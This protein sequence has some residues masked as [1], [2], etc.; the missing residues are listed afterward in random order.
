MIK[1]ISTSHLLSFFTLLFPLFFLATSVSAKDNHTI[2][3][4]FKGNPATIEEHTNKG[5]WL[6]VMYW[7]SNCHICNQEASEYAAFHK[8]HSGT[9]AT[10]LGISLDGLAGKSEAE[11]FI[12]RHDITFP[13]LLGEA[14]DI[15]LQFVSRAGGASFGTPSFLLF[16]PKG[17]LRA[18]ELGAVPVNVLE[19]YIKKNSS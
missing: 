17:K 6:L 13:N 15:A 11:S 3:Q 9:D 2:F 16:D 14:D 10:V 19:A 4:D 18:A 1:K 12:N 7:A 8:R 5:K